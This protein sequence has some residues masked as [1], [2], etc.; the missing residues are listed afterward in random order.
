MAFLRPNLSNEDMTNRHPQNNEQASRALADSPDS[1]SP[2][3]IDLS[4]IGNFTFDHI[5][6]WRHVEPMVI[7][8]PQPQTIAFHSPN[9]EILRIEEDGSVYVHGRLAGTDREIF[10]AL[11]QF[12]RE[13]R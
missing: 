12:S 5:M 10:E 4:H 1:I 13:Q 9:E 6:D 7:S 2:I 11:Q 8:D 3:S